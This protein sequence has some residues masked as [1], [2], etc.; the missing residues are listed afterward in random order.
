MWEKSF[1]KPHSDDMKSLTIITVILLFCSCSGSSDVN[2]LLAEREQRDLELYYGLGE[3][4]RSEFRWMAEDRS[5]GEVQKYFHKNYENVERINT[6]VIKV[7]RDLEEVKYQLAKE[8]FEGSIKDSDSKLIGDDDLVIQEFYLSK[9]NADATSS[10]FSFDSEYGKRARKTFL[11]FRKSLTENMI[12]SSNIR[13]D[14]F[15]FN[16]TGIPNFKNDK[17]L[18]KSIER[19]VDAS[20]VGLDDREPLIKIYSDLS[21]SEEQWK[22]FLPEEGNC[23]ELFRTISYLEK[24]VLLARVEAFRL[25]RSRF[26]GEDYG[27][28]K[29]TS[30]ARGEDI[31]SP[32]D[33]FEIAVGIAA[34]NSFHEPVVK[35]NSKDVLEGRYVKE[36]MGRLKIVAPKNKRQQTLVYK[37]T[38]TILNKSGVPKTLTWENRSTS[39]NQYAL[40]KPASAKRIV[41]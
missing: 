33:T 22:K 31:V 7:I 2:P 28:D 13:E 3:E 14:K 1:T 18:R 17:A 8:L 25:M 12:E 29:I 9:A 34:F 19:L 10:N 41:L 26:G 30:F 4:L 40:F 39:G 24:Q 20:E 27:F 35:C 36:G 32:G 6:S 21:F 38:V 37:G 11:Q 15:S 23:I 5:A 16:D